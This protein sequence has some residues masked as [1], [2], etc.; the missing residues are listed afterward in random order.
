MSDNL[1]VVR[2]S[3]DAWNAHNPDA[4]LKLLHDKHVMESDTIPQPITGQEGARA[5]MGMYV[6]AFPDLHFKVDQLTASGNYVISRYT[7]TGT[8]QGPLGNIPP[9]ERRGEVH[10]CTVAEIENGQ[11]VREWLYWDSAHLL[12]QLGVLP[13]A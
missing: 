10:G 13:A 12:R 9:T 4:W 11:I 5:F 6:T 7:A 3:W 2:Q 8:H 1:A